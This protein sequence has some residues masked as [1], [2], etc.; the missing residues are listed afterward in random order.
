M[1]V[2]LTVVPK[3][4]FGCDEGSN[5]SCLIGWLD[6]LSP[7]VV[8]YDFIDSMS[9]RDRIVALNLYGVR[10]RKRPSM[11]SFVFSREIPVLMVDGSF[12]INY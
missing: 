8:D 3:S 6:Q 10:V 2:V 7:V 1:T 4:P 12:R 9:A 5:L 11:Q